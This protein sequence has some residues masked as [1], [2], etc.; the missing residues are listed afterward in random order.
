MKNN[1]L[2]NKSVNK[3]IVWDATWGEIDNQIAQVK[4]AEQRKNKRRYV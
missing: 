2:K 3:G 1:N 4:E